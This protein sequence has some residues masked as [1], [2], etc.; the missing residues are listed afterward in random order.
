MKG[1][2][3]SSHICSMVE[4]TTVCWIEYDEPRGH[5]TTADELARTL[6]DLW[7]H[8]IAADPGAERAG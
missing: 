8:S 5:A 2:R 3:C 7:Y 4:W 1:R 6:A